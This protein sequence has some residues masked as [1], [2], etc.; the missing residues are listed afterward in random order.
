MTTLQLAVATV[1]SFALG[2]GD[3]LRSTVSSQG[4]VADLF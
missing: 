2:G 3:T 1:Q 4:H